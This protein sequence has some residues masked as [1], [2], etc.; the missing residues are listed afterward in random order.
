V[1]PVGIALLLLLAV[2]AHAEY[3]KAEAKLRVRA[4]KV[5]SDYVLF[6]KGRSLKSEALASYARAKD[7]NPAYDADGKIKEQLDALEQAPEG[8]ATADVRKVKSG[9]DVAK[10]YDKL[11]KLKTERSDRY[12]FD[13]IRLDPSKARI[14]RVMQE[15]KKGKPDRA[16][17]LLA[18]LR[19]AHPEGNY[20]AL[21]ADLARRDV[22]MIQ[23]KDHAIV[24]WISLPKGWKKGKSYPVLVTVDGAGSNFL[25]ACRSSSR[26][27]GKRPWIVLAP[28]TF[29]NTNA[30]TPKK[31][32]W[33][34]A[35]LIERMNN[36]GAG[37][38]K[39]DSEGLIALIETV[40][41]QFGG[42]DRFA[43]TGFSGGGNLTYGI[44]LLHPERVRFAMPACANFAGHGA[45]NAG[46]P[47]EGGPPILIYT[48]EKDPHRTWTHGKEGGVP[49][50]EPQ[51][52][53]AVAVLKDKGFTNVKRQMLPGVKHSSLHAK[54]WETADDLAR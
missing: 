48:G 25:G 46:T 30:L 27:R 16:G 2:P 5:W 45:A 53:R 35:D 38:F 51:T 52:D 9:K 8:A 49:G 26:S 40:K 20:T 39:F 42:E 34:D 11:A 19:S 21:V 17:T 24:G 32:P 13:A 54:V 3:S 15:I 6:C 50:I 4:A 31:Y 41:E 28:C 10:V 43:I 29:V 44:T 22:A 18:Q 7:L 33:Y 36:D 47:K 14:G 12:R 23:G 37:R 1:K